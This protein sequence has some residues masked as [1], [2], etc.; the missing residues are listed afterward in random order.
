ML[1][2]ITFKSLL[3]IRLGYPGWKARYYKEKFGAEGSNEI[4]GTQKF[5]VS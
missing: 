3:Q 1:N 2:K 4:E 5:V